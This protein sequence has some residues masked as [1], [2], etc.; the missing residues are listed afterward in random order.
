[1]ES[2]DS[3]PLGNLFFSEVDS[4]QSVTVLSGMRVLLPIIALLSTIMAMLLGQLGSA[5]RIFP[6]NLSPLGASSN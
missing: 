2:C 4:S 1:M 6:S 5:G 3:S